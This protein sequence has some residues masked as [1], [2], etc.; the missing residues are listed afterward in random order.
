MRDSIGP[1]GYSSLPPP[2]KNDVQGLLIRTTELELSVNT[3]AQLI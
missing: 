2:V 3:S 1:N